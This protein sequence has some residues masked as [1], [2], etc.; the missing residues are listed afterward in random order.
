MNP[1]VRGL[2][3]QIPATLAR[4]VARTDAELAEVLRVPVADVRAA[5]AILY[6]QRKVDRCWAFVVLAP[7]VF[8]REVS[9]A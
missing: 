3:R 2:L 1:V 9:A 5:I 7:P 4:D 6:H 8:R